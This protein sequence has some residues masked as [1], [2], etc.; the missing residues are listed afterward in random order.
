M[1]VIGVEE[2]I[3]TS[4]YLL[5]STS[6]WN[7]WPWLSHT[8]KSLVNSLIQQSVKWR[9]WLLQ[10]VDRRPPC[11][12][13]LAAFTLEGKKLPRPRKATSD[14]SVNV[15]KHEN[16]G[17]KQGRSVLQFEAVQRHFF[18]VPFTVPYLDPWFHSK[19]IYLER[20][21]RSSRRSKK[22]PRSLTTC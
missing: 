22:R 7:T 14:M 5:F 3:R 1:Q 8:A 17:E 18:S 19:F 6:K 10:S 21:C 9:F 13:G 20:R 11:C 2:A 12:S 16:A 15:Q 4:W